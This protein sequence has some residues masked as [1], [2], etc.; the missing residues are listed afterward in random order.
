MSN[1]PASKKDC[2]DCKYLHPIEG[3]PIF[4]GYCLIDV[5]DHLTKSETGTCSKFAKKE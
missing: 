4:S 1:K 5:S 3:H 2:K